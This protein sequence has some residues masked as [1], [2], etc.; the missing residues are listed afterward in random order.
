M[1]SSA[2]GG[3]GR[4]DE[5]RLLDLLVAQIEQEEQAAALEVGSEGRLFP[6]R[7]VQGEDDIVADAYRDR[8]GWSAE[9]LAMHL[10]D[11]P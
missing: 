11:E 6:L 1:T 9:E 8:G 4:G 5:E 3:A 2:S 10:L 7:L